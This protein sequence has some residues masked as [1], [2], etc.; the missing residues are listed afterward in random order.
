[1]QSRE[2]TLRSS[3][4]DLKSGP[5]L[6]KALSEKRTIFLLDETG[7]Y[8]LPA[9]TRSLAPRGERFQVKVPLTRNHL[10]VIGGVTPDGKISAE[11]H[12]QALDG[13]GVIFFLTHLLKHLSDRLLVI[14]DGSPIHCRSEVVQVFLRQVGSKHIRIEEFPPYA[15]DLNPAEGL[16]DQLKYHELAN[17]PCQDLE[18]LAYELRLAL[19]RVRARLSLVQGF[20]GQPKLD[21]SEFKKV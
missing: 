10:S 14:W 20:F 2:T 3:D 17:T 19:N 8:L 12:T 6:K 1:V 5:V 4:G 18:A 21:I 16:W 13:W 7:F 11:I 9:I 15:P